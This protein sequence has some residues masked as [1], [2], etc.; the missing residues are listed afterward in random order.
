MFACGFV[1]QHHKQ[2]TNKELVMDR[3]AAITADLLRAYDQA[4]LLQRR[5]ERL[6]RIR[7]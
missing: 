7:C 3:I 6:S 5:A 1:Q 4:T 2:T